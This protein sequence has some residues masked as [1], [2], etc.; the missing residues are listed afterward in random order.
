MLKLRHGR[1]EGVCGGMPTPLHRGSTE[2][3][4]VVH[5]NRTE[6]PSTVDGAV[7]LMLG[8]MPDDERIRIASMA[9]SDLVDLHFGLGQ[10]VRN[11]LVLWNDNNLLMTA[12]GESNADD[13][14]AV[15]V[16]AFWERLREELPK[17]H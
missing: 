9:E 11:Y 7:R 5:R 12:T 16:R 17:L 2:R 15:I 1:L 10:W 8:L 4:S 13:A 6:L 3:R 14:S